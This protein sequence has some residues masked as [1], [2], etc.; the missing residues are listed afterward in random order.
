LGIKLQPRSFLL[1]TTYSVVWYLL[2]MG[3]SS[4]S[5]VWSLLSVFNSWGLRLVLNHQV[6]E[7]CDYLLK[8]GVGLTQVLIFG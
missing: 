3:I 7:Y 6:Y 5:V 1:P 4:Y 2:V 8:C